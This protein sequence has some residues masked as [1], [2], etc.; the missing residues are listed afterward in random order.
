LL[1][2]KG[3]VVELLSIDVLVLAPKIPTISLDN[4]EDQLGEGAG[5]EQLDQE[6]EDALPKVDGFDGQHAAE[7]RKS[8]Q[9][10]GEFDEVGN[11]AIHQEVDSHHQVVDLVSGGLRNRHE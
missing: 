3:I 5:G 11:K 8:P 7:E 6:P 9:G 4:R 10:E 1:T 2:S